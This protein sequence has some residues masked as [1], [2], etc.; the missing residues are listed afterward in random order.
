M[1]IVVAAVIQFCAKGRR[2][3]FASLAQRFAGNDIAVKPPCTGQRL[4][5]SKPESML[6]SGDMWLPWCK[7]S[8]YSLRA[9]I[10]TLWRHL[11]GNKIPVRRCW[12][13][14]SN[15]GRDKSFVYDL[16]KERGI[17]R[18]RVALC[19]DLLRLS[20]CSCDLC[21]HFSS[22]S[23]WCLG[24]TPGPPSLMKILT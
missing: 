20:P 17:V 15:I 5:A 16:N 13:T 3:W 6:E 24:S 18:M 11:A 7:M 10:I 21:L 22:F 23:G 4:S 8:T 14:S 12:K 1:K 9:K 19:H 2:R